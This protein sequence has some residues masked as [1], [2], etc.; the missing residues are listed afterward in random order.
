MVQKLVW[1]EAES[2]ENMKFNKLSHNDSSTENS[3][4]LQKQLIK[5]TQ[6]HT[7]ESFDNVQR[8]NR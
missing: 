8:G 7:T 1:E 3:I 6:L 4:R 2:L 5:Q